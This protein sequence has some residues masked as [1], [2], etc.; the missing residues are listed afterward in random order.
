M[1]FVSL[2]L[3]LIDF[4]NLGE[5]DSPR[6][7]STKTQIRETLQ[8][9]GCFEATFKNFIPL[10]LRKSVSDGIRQLFDLP[11]P[12]KLLNKKSSKPYNIGYV[13][14]NDYGPLMES[15]GI[16]DVLSSQT[17]DTFANLMWPDK[18]N[19]TFRFNPFLI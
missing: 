4:S 1:S 9:Y 12:I 5:N 19:T 13:G 11:L 17:V 2:K 7:E 6:C 14:H 16:D 15:M 10:E 3:P 18:G 8:E